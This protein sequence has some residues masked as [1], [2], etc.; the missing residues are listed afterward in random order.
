MVGALILQQDVP[1]GFPIQ[2]TRIPG[3]PEPQTKVYDR[4]RSQWL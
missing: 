1:F 4:P 2:T 3:P